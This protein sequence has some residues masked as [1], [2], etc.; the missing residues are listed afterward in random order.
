MTTLQN[1]I[2]VIIDKQTKI[3]KTKIYEL[4]K[5]YEKKTEKQ[6]E[7][8]PSRRETVKKTVDKQKSTQP[9]NVVNVKRPIKQPVPAEKTHYRRE[10]EYTPNSTDYS[11]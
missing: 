3:M 7:R 9:S 8:S 2:D 5:N 6:P 1:E 10:I 4:I 11:E